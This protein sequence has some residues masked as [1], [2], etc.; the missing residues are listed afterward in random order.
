MKRPPNDMARFF[1]LHRLCSTGPPPPSPQQ[2]NK[3]PRRLVEQPTF[4][5]LVVGPSHDCLVSRNRP[6]TIGGGGPDERIVRQISTA[7]P[8]MD[9][10]AVG[11]ASRRGRRRRPTIAHNHGN[12]APGGRDRPQWAVKRIRPVGG[13]Q[14]IV[15]WMATNGRIAAGRRRSKGGARSIAK[16]IDESSSALTVE[17][18][19]RSGQRSATRTG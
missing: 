4:E 1:A 13:A 8:R 5:C 11:G 6:E 7:R 2:R 19:P 17:S 9:M 18:T 15:Y 3:A 10:R 16:R 14:Q 12:T